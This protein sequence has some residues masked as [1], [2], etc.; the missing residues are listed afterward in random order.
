MIGLETDRLIFR[1]WQKADH[2][3]FTEFYQSAENSR[4]VGGVKNAEETWRLMCTY[5]GHYV[6]HG[7]SKLA[8]IEK[9]SQGFI[10]TIGL[11]NS[12]AW[13]EP[14]IGYW[15]LP[16]GQGKGYGIEGGL[17]VKKYALKTLK[18]DSLVSY[19][20][21]ENEPSKRLALNLGGHFDKEIELLNFGKHEVYRY[22]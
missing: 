19:V 21:G 3:L 15:L 4:F 14:E 10:G 12:P 2:K 20:A 5:L 17:A 7:Y 1:Q 9:E 6:L 16:H 13:P 8:V 18:F 22:K 11:W